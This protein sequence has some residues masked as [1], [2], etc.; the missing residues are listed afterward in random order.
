M[1]NKKLMMLTI[2]FTCLL[3]VSAVSAAENATEDIIAD[4]ASEDVVSV[5]DINQAIEQIEH[6]ETIRVT[7]NGTFTALQN[8][9]D[10]A[11]NGSTITLENDYAYDEGFDTN[12]IK[13]SKPLTIDGNGYTIDASLQSRIFYLA[14]DNII[15]KNMTFK[16]G[17]MHYD[18]GYRGCGGVVFNYGVCCTISF[19]NFINNSAREAGAIY[20]ENDGKC[21]IISCT[22]DNCHAQYKG[23][24]IYGDCNIDSST[25]NNCTGD[26][27]Y[28]RRGDLNI[29]SCVFNYCG[30]IQNE[31][32]ANCIISLCTFNN[33]TNIVNYGSVTCTVSSCTFN[34]CSSGD[35]GVI[36][37]MAFDAGESLTCTIS[38]CNFNNCYAREWGGVIYNS[39]GPGN[40]ITCTVSSCTFNEC[41]AYEYG[42]AICTKGGKCNIYSS[43]FNKCHAKDGG[44]IYTK[45]CECN[46]HSSTFNKCSS[47]DNASSIYNYYGGAEC[48]VVGSN[49][50]GLR[51]NELYGVVSISECIFNYSPSTKVDSKI[52]AYDVSNVYNG[53]KYLVAILKDINDKVISGV[54]LTVLLN[55][56]TSTPTTDAN[57]QIKVSTDGLAPNKYSA[58]ITFAGNTKYTKSSKSVS[59]IV[60]KATPKL[61]AKAKTF[62]KSDKTKKYTV[63]LKNNKKLIKGGTVKITV[64]KKTYSAKTSSKGVATFKLTK[65]TKKGKFTATVKS[66]G[67]K[68]YNAKTLKNIKITV[69]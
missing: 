58:T 51:G 30:S 36:E 5:E 42:G 21:N 28:N 43:T 29:T 7:D 40:S 53:G 23:A 15:L 9:I 48:T 16:N 60:K 65:L 26:V 67:N 20:N 17:Y 11:V 1:L 69:K 68:Y 19:C 27:F 38:S 59:V 54:K 34:N 57:G 2:I 24:A 25:F 31:D 46:I 3:A 22:F 55:G 63:T 33:C 6:E 47:S 61:T 18:N 12:G 52:I 50:T 35:G 44:A 4:V 45:G 8:K 41:Y 56:K 32:G 39:D 10:N 14:C 49:F 13:I 66:V 64:N 37:N 62:K